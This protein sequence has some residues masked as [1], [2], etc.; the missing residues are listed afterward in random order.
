MVYLN[1]YLRFYY[2][3]ILNYYI[4]PFKTVVF[5]QNPRIIYYTTYPL[6]LFIKLFLLLS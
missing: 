3:H 5:M 6:L 1:I 2:K 4:I